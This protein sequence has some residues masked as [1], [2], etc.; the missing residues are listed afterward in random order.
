MKYVIRILAYLIK[1]SLLVAGIYALMRLTGTASYGAAEL[2]GSTRGHI[3]L[4]LLGLLSIAN[5]WLGYVTREVEIDP[6]QWRKQ[7]T[8]AMTGSGYSLASER[9]GVLT[10]RAD[11]I[12]KRVWH[13]WEEALTVRIVDGQAHISG[14]R[15][16]VV[17]TIF[18]VI[19]T[20]GAD[21]TESK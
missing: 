5:P 7:I 8:N 17:N 11:N 3:L 15:K 6:T 16:Q 12:L 19:P 9:N 13:L 21:M 10:Y 18:R 1:M 20:G 14:P 4:I 2:F